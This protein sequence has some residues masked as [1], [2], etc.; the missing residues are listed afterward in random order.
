MLDLYLLIVKCPFNEIKILQ[1]VTIDLKKTFQFI[2]YSN[3]HLNSRETVPLQTNWQ[4]KHAFEFRAVPVTNKIHFCQNNELTATV[5]ISYQNIFLYFFNK[6][7][8]K[9]ICWPE[10]QLLH[11][12]A[13][14]PRLAAKLPRLAAMLLRSAAADLLHP[15]AEPRA[16]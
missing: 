11:S 13:R 5:H 10:V 12:A 3:T 14:L 4:Q 16:A 15:L 7:I 1:W 2:Y 8:Q 9:F 6:I